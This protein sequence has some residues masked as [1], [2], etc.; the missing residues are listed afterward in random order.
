MLV[1]A[2]KEKVERGEIAYGVS[3]AWPTP[4]LIQFYGLVGYDWVF[5]DAEHDPMSPETV[6]R[7]VEACH[8]AGMT[9]FVRVPENTPGTILRFLEAGAM[10]IIA[11]HLNTAEE[12]RALVAATRYFPEGR[13]GAGSQGRVANFSLTQTPAEYFDRANREIWTWGIIEEERGVQNLDEI[14]AVDGLD[15]LGVGPGDLSMSL[16]LRGQPGH[17]TVVAMKEDSER[18]ITDSG[19]ILWSLVKT[20]EEHSAVVSRGAKLIF[21]H[22][23]P[24]FASACRTFLSDLKAAVPAEQRPS[25]PADSG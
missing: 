3:H 10:G 1:N 13:R 11:P 6:G 24:L 8:L 9:P 2:V 14:L 20:P 16:G 25:K 7:L 22:A 5:I 21:T 19:K 23:V 15:V 18:R 4:D 12:A 17:P